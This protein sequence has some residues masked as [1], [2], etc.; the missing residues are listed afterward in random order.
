MAWSVAEAVLD[1]QT[2]E[3]EVLAEILARLPR[4]ILDRVMN[5]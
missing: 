4:P 1:I 2:G 3:G 5:E